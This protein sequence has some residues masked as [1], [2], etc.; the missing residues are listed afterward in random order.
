M[1]YEK[2]YKEEFKEINNRVYNLNKDRQE[3]FDY[4][5]DSFGTKYF[6]SDGTKSHIK[7][8]I[9]IKMLGTVPTG[10]YHLISS[11]K[12]DLDDCDK[13]YKKDMKRQF[14]E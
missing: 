9:N 5:Y 3:P 2:L 6:I 1:D 14:I 10:N 13:Q 7:H 12:I 11:L 8:S 4:Y